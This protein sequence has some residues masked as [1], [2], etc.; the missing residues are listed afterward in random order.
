MDR[1]MMS[2]CVA[3]VCGLSGNLLAQ[4]APK[5]VPIPRLTPADGKTIVPASA[6]LADSQPNNG[7]VSL[8]I[9]LVE[10][11]R[12]KVSGEASPQDEKPADATALFSDPKSA[13]DSAGG[14][15]SDD[16]VAAFLDAC[17]NQGDCV[18][19]AAPRLLLQLGTKGTFQSGAEYVPITPDEEFPLLPAGAVISPAK[20]VLVETAPVNESVASPPDAQFFGTK[21]EA[22]VTQPKSGLLRVAVMVEHSE[23]APR[24]GRTVR[25]VQTQ[26]ELKPGESLKISGMKSYMKGVNFTSLPFWGDIPVI[27]E[28]LFS[29]TTAVDLETELILLV[30]PELVDAE[31]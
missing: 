1:R 26:V 3:L 8:E 25:R 22:T 6:T 29:K 14:V 5:P 7:F 18:V 20:M 15:M 28:L 13:A 11:R 17:Q 2:A 9:R 23:M 19:L 16:E 30:R 4:D 27:G 12:E 24:G 31:K 21:A 10:L